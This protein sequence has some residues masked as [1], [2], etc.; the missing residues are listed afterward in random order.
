[1]Q[2][3]LLPPQ[4][5]ATAN[6]LAEGAIGPDH[7]AA[8]I[9]VISRIPQAVEPTRQSLAEEMLADN[10]R[11]LSPKGIAEM[12]ARILAHLDPDG[13]LTDD[14]DR[15]RQRRIT[16][17]EQDAQHMS[18]IG[19][20]L[21]PAT[22]AM[23][24]MVLAAWAAPGMNN[25]DDDQS[26][27]GSSNGIDA[28]VLRAAATRDS[29]SDGQRNHDALKALLSAALDGGL[30]GQSHRGLPPHVII[31]ITES[32]LRERAGVGT[33]TTGATLPISDLIELAARSQMHLAVF[34]DHSKEI[35]YLGRA[36][37][38]ASESQRFALFAA[39]G[40]CTKPGCPAPFSHTEIHHAEQDFAAGGRTD[41][42]ALAPAC[43]P[44]NRMVGDRPGQYSTVKITTGSA[45]GAYGWSRNTR[46]G[47]PPLTPTVNRLHLVDETFATQKNSL[48]D[49]PGASSDRG[50]TA[51]RT[52]P[53]RLR[54]HR[55]KV[56][57]RDELTATDR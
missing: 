52:P 5:P 55:T 36:K 3:E 8:I 57:R 49:T 23:F 21:D 30:L 18:K 25:P 53:S 38:L 26:P 13:R 47:V 34:A 43:G 40:G 28:G 41:V 56:R 27:R 9:G 12:G 6:A 1:M 10:A 15:A 37:R 4:C 44:H 39:Y 46:S 19:G 35:L 2:G 50:L 31:K 42:D 51:P 11:V 24:G 54:N 7:V 29:R 22:H 16:L 33:T 17:R 20:W 48:D 45:R 14:R 32:E